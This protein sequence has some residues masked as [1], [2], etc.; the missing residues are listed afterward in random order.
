VPSMPRAGG[1]GHRSRSSPLATLHQPGVSHSKVRDLEVKDPG[2]GNRQRIG[3]ESS[4]AK[5]PDSNGSRSCEGPDPTKTG[6][7]FEA[8]GGGFPRPHR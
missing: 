2:G 4:G 3:A 5:N 6:P 7:R 1:D 8:G